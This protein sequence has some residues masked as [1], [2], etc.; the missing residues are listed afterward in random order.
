MPHLRVL[1]SR[2]PRKKTRALIWPGIV[3]KAENSVIPEWAVDKRA[4]Q[5]S[6][7][8]LRIGDE[9]SRRARTITMTTVEQMKSHGETIHDMTAIP[10]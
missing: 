8:A 2:R 1:P 5:P 4:G 6:T 3:G 7:S 10:K 9:N